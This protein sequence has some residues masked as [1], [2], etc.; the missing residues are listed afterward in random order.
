[1]PNVNNG[2]LQPAGSV[3]EYG[4]EYKDLTEEFRR[5]GNFTEYWDADAEASYLWN[6]SDFISFESPEAVRR[7]CVY[8]KEKG[9]LGVMYWEHAADTTRELLGVIAS[10]MQDK[11]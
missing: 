2:L 1:M 11:S 9:L 5:A 6:G 10:V 3:G 7:K 8:T 4:P